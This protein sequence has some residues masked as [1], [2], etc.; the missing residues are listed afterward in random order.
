M[1][2]PKETV[3]NEKQH[4]KKSNL[5]MENAADDEVEVCN[6]NESIYKI[7]FMVTFELMD[8][9]SADTDISNSLVNVN[10]HVNII[11]R[12]YLVW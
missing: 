9:D 12:K 6:G 8:N 3:L 11:H 4:A 10:Q 1:V 5:A 7:G 2:T